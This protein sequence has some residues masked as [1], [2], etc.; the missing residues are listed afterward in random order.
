MS[1]RASDW[2]FE[3]IPNDTVVQSLPDGSAAD[4]FVQ[5]NRARSTDTLLTVPLIGWT[6]RARAT[7]CGF[8]VAKYGPQQSTDSW[9][10]DCGNGVR[11]D[12]SMVTGNDPA[13]T[14]LAIG[15]AFVTEWIAHLRARFGGA[16]AGGVRY[17]NLDNEPEL[18]NSTHRDVH[19]Q[20]LGY[21]ELLQRSIAY[22]RA[23]K[24]A[25]P[26]A[27]TLG[28]VGWGWT[29]YFYSAADMAAGGS[30]WTTR[31]DRRAHGDTP[32]VEWYLRE[33]RAQ[34]E[35]DGRRLLDFLDLHY[36]P[37][38]AG[39]SLQGAGG[40]STQALRLR[41]T[42]SLWDATYTDESWID[43][44]EGGP[45]VQLIP[46]MRAWVDAHYPGTKLAV[47]EYNWGALDH[48][49]GA[50]AQA[51][52]LGIFG[53]EGLDLATLWAPPTPA[54][55]GAFAFRMFRN[56]DGAG[57]Q[58]GDIR[59][60]ARSTDQDLV[61]IYAAERTADRILT[62]VVINKSTG[63]RTVPLQL[64]GA[65]AMPAARVFR[66]SGADLSHIA[67][68]ADVTLSAGATVTLPE[69]SITLLEIPL[70]AAA[71]E[72]RVV[73]GAVRD[74]GNVMPGVLVT[75]SGGCGSSMTTT[76][77]GTYSLSGP[78][79]ASCIVTPTLAG[80]AFLPASRSVV[81]DEDVAGLDFT[82]IAVGTAAL[83]GVVTDVNGTGL[84][85]VSISVTGAAIPAVTS[86]TGADGSYV[87]A[88][89]AAGASITVA[90]S[91]DGF[92]FAPSNQSMP[93]LQGTVTAAPF[94]AQSGTYTRY[95]A[96]GATG[97]L[98]DTSLA[99]LNPTASA[100]VATLRF[101]T[102]DGTH[103]ERTLSIAARTRATIDP[104]DEPALAAAE[105][106]TSVTSTQPLVIDR[107]MSWGGG[108]YGAHAEASI[109]APA[110]T[111][112]LAEGATGAFNL[113][114]L[115]QNPHGTS[116]QVRVRYL[117][118]SG[119]TLEKSYTLPPASRT[120]IWVNQEDFGASGL[121]LAQGDVSAVIEVTSG[122]PIIVERAM[123]LDLPGQPFGAGHE[124]AGVTAPATQW[125]LAE[126]ATGPYFDLFVLLANPGAQPAEIDA[127]YLL[128]DG[129]TVAKHYTVAANARFT[130]WV[131][132]EDTRLADTAV[133]TRIRSSN[134]VPVIVER[135]LWWP[136]P[137]WY[138]AHNSPGSTATGTTW[139]LADGEVGGARGVETY[140]L[141]A[142]TSPQQASVEVTVVFD[143]ATHVARTFAV[144]GS[145]RFNVDVG[146]EFPGARNRRFGVIV[147]SQG[148]TPAP[149]VVERAMYWDAAGQWWAA[150]TNALATRLR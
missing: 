102:P 100:T 132:H 74:G 45:A 91:R 72:T 146:A 103:V 2:Y 63:P 28:P 18:W 118:P 137:G 142:N 95:F 49:N 136:D 128:P 117:R 6:P 51:D 52:V 125:F 17:F 143:D 67:R 24:D 110:S 124:S 1:N 114:Y 44:T 9:R 42:R 29:A 13:D 31:P 54:Q 105:F 78:R 4:Q 33:M 34:G 107:T 106:S 138:E 16:D 148:A 62:I 79:D 119:P 20:P 104:E 15:P 139:A 48:I 92:T 123:Y 93:S 101:E 126:G 65:P 131:D 46:R 98:F 113:F 39:V 10:P 86:T 130:V 50:L 120:N 59:V 12:G 47:T 145:S 90:A 81:L 32:L 38:A 25:E 43:G 144:A 116:A 94:V 115:L 23:I 21:D 26:R 27:L 37:Q 77:D 14:S 55:P 7:D 147:D 36:Y 129:T 3:N 61:A 71:P 11:P 111:W 134:G 41:S 121:A 70:G 88:G 35:R 83:S 8:S 135:A 75:L 80:R 89:I 99:L 68:L 112:Y 5:A 82:A 30:W 53:R 109:P 150:G 57:H 97:A 66:Y 127:T 22:A 108:G 69:R 141:L 122:P 60:R 96:E 85:G 76:G 56:Y 140:V 84:P 149:I 73:S 87:V 19:P 58:F 64:T 133:S 40:T